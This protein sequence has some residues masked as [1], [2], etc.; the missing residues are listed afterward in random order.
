MRSSKA[1]FAFSIAA[2]LALFAAAADA[3]G[4]KDKEVQKLIAQA[5][6]EDYLNVEFD[7]AEA[8]LKRAVDTCK[9]EADAC[10]GEVLAKAYVGLAT[11]HGV[12]QQ[13]L[14]VA[15]ADLVNALKADKNAAL[16]EGLTTPDLE[17]KFK[18]AQDEVGGGAGGAEPTGGSD[19]GGAGPG[20]APPV[21][22]DFPHEPVAEQAV[23]TPVPV[24]A[25]I[26]EELGVAKA[27]VRYKPYGGTKWE[28]LTLEKM[29]EGFG[30][31]IPCN[32]VT[33][34]GELRYYI[35]A[36][37]EGGTPIATAGSLKAPFRVAI[38]QSIKGDKP[39]LPGQD[40][41]KK[42]ASRADCP[43][44][45]PGCEGAGGGKPLD[46]ICDAT[47]ECAQGLVCLNGVCAPGE[48]DVDGGPKTGTQHVV[49]VSAQ[50]D[51]AY[52]SDGQSVC[53]GSSSASY[54]CM[55]PD[56]DPSAQFFGIPRDVNGT[57]GIS[58]GLAFGGARIFAGS[59]YFFDFGSM[60]GLGLGARVGYAFG[61]PYPCE[62]GVD[63]C[64]ARPEESGTPV[65]NS[66]F[67]AHL[68]ARASWKFLKPNPEAGD[69]APHVFIGG[70]GAQ[71]NASVPVTVCDTLLDPDGA[72]GPRDPEDP[73]EACSGGNNPVPAKQRNVDAYQLAGLTFVTFGGGATYMIVRNFGISAELKFMVLFPTVG[74]TISPVIAPVV[75]F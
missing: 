60:G 68:E 30:G 1:I 52:V 56:S 23:N 3:A 17:A 51:L 16:I 19:T 65:A 18:E 53:S 45:L 37:D 12:G 70:G 67:P 38:R 2:G 47:A 24:Y 48:G 15:K 36:S 8:K 41:P 4:K 72:E 57:N 21:A 33:S 39:S 28:T 69:F 31:L 20:G 66:F 10:S 62:P 9:K 13:K 63:G 5:L 73:D 6:D 14:D 22:S 7:K 54:V 42:C 40:P 64:P 35:I 27:I 58:G 26:P 49:S 71:V 32:A 43:P 25:E 34:G 44:G 11:V 75:A 74:F 46:A 61:G 59:D 29:D 55:L 50:F